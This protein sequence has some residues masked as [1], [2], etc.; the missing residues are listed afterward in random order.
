[1]RCVR[2]IA[3]LANLPIKEAQLE[4]NH[5]FM[6]MIDTAQCHSK[7]CDKAKARQMTKI[8]CQRGRHVLH[9]IFIIVNSAA[10]E[11]RYSKVGLVAFYFYAKNSLNS[12]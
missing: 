9:R 2:Q 1:M 8:Y 11:D 10:F 7:R 12:V 4:M 5:G 3:H 6:Y